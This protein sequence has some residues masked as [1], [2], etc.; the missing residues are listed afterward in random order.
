MNAS[1]KIFVEYYSAECTED[2]FNKGEVGRAT[3]YWTSKDLPV[4]GGFS[5]VSDALKAICSA[6][7]FDYQPEGWINW[8]EE[9]GDDAGRFDFQV[10]VCDDNTE[11]SKSEIEAWKNGEIKLYNCYIVAHLSV[12]S[13]RQLTTV[14]CAT[15]NN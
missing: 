12:R 3:S 1:E 10:L 4:E 8:L 11:A 9:Y 7:C 13:I 5:S 6:N 2:D 14:E 15:F